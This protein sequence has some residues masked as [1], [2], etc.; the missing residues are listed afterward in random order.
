[1]ISNDSKTD[2]KKVKNRHMDLL[3]SPE[4]L[5][6]QKMD[7]FY[8]LFLYFNDH[9]DLNTPFMWRTEVLA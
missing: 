8:I 6:C 4:S 5:R 1:M 2:V 9:Y 7:T 3:T